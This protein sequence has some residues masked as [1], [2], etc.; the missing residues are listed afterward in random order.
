MSDIPYTLPEKAVII[1]VKIYQCQRTNIWRLMNRINEFNNVI[2]QGI[3]NSQIVME[4]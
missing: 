3:I 1:T 4:F 2:H